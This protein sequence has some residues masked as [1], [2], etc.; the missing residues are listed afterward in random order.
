MKRFTENPGGLSVIDKPTGLAAI[1][2]NIGAI[3]TYRRAN[4]EIA[5]EQCRAM[6]AY[7]AM[8]NAAILSAMEAACYRISPFGED[9]YGRILAAYTA[10]AVNRILRW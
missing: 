2:Q 10:G 7:T 9:M 8:E 3:S 1:S 4:Q 6:L 5:H